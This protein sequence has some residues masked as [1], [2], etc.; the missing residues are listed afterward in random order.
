[1]SLEV[2]SPGAQALVVDLGRP[3]YRHLGVPL[4]CAADRLSHQIAN[5]IVGNMPGAGAVE[6]ALGGLSV[7]AEYDVTVAVCGA[8][9]EVSVAG[10][11]VPMWAAIRLKK[12]DVLGL[13]GTRLG[14]R[15]YLAVTGGVD[16]ER[17][18]GSLSTYPPAGLGANGGRALSAGDV[19]EI[20]ESS[21]EPNALPE[22]FLPQ[23]SNHVT[24]RVRSV[25]EYERLS[26]EAQ[27]RLFVSP[28]EASRQT[29]RMAAR[30]DGGTLELEDVKPMVSGPLLPGTLQVPPDG[31]PILSLADGHCTG[32]YARAVQ[33]I[34]ADMW[35]AGQVGPGTRVSFRRVFAE[36]VPGIRDAHMAHW[37]S[38][39]EGYQL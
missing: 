30:L 1:M 7:K 34:A 18:F 2:L 32:G 19:I 24:L 22:G 9:C 5:W 8:S 28:W 3:G 37:G 16:G 13:S 6:C 39:I 17:H 14:A 10:K 27:R 29:S 25:A 35:I 4:S 31:R 20:G 36:E 11:A 33:V 15:V 21:A 12:G 23:I 26:A 38:L